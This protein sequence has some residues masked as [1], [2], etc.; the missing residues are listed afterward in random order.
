MLTRMCCQSEDYTECLRV[1]KYDIIM[2]NWF[3]YQH[4]RIDLT[5]KTSTQ[6]F[7]CFELKLSFD[8]FYYDDYYGMLSKKT[9]VMAPCSCGSKFVLVALW[10]TKCN[11][12]L[13][14]AIF[15]D[16]DSKKCILVKKQVGWRQIILQRCVGGLTFDFKDLAK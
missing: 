10:R 2:Q 16:R 7:T 4:A 14:H 12:L 9:A 8:L 13:I 5:N 11:R 3:T 6:L 1:C 15:Y